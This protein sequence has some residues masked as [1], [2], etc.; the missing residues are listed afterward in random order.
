VRHEPSARPPTAGSR[1]PIGRQPALAPTGFR[2][3]A[4]RRF[5]LHMAGVFT[6]HESLQEIIDLAV[7]EFLDRLRTV[8]GF[9]EALTAAERERQRRAGV[10]MAD[11][12]VTEPDPE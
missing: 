10:Q 6:G 2:A 11:F 12:D 9:P 4:R 7:T 3:S 8:P 5:E 1:G